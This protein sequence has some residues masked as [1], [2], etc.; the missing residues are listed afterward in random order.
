MVDQKHLTFVSTNCTPPV[1]DQKHTHGV[2]TTR[3]MYFWST[4]SGLTTSTSM[5][6]CIYIYIQFIT[7][8]Y[9]HTCTSKYNVIHNCIYKYNNIIYIYLQFNF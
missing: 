3:G 5:Y 8:I 9:I 6:V 7:Y 2:S 1:F 4:M